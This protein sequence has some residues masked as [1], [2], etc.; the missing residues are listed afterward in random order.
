MKRNYD[1]YLL[2]IPAFIYFIIFQYG[3]MYGLQIAFKDY[4]PVKGFLNSDWVGL[5]HLARFLSSYNFWLL[6]K[7][8]L[9]INLYELAVAFPAPIIFALLLNE[10]GKARFKKFVQM[11]SYAPHFISTVVMVGI[12]MIFLSATGGTVNHIIQFFGLEPIA[13]LQEPGWFK[14]VYVLS[15][16]WQSLGWGT[17][18]YLAVLSGVDKQLYEAAQIDGASKLKRIIHID[19]PQLI[20]TA[21]ILLILDV[22]R[23]MNVG[24][25]KVFLLQNSLNL[26]ASDVISTYV[27]RMGILSADFSFATAVGLF[28]AVIN[29]ILLVSVNQFIRKRSETS[30]W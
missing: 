28:N 1:L 22:G 2:S 16:V 17:I 23:M 14:T 30:L 4:N 18:I 11:V 6:I 25:E 19:I 7:N 26:S 20:P 10:I 8:T 24:F 3:P 12:L 9:F 29:F 5:E 27:Y 15:G 21:I 13:F